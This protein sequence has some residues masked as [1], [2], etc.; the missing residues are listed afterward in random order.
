MIAYAVPCK[1]DIGLRTEFHVNAGPASQ[2]IAGS[3]PVN[4][5]QRWPNT[6]LSLGLLY[7]LRKQAEFTQCCFN[8]DPL[9]S[10][11]ARY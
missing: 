8:V 3:M 2:P 9:S 7:T 1:E 10:T 11:L 6:N 4:R 5:L